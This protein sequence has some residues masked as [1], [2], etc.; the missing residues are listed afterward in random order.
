[1]AAS[2]DSFCSQTRLV[3]D[4]PLGGFSPLNPLCSWCGRGGVWD[5]FSL[6]LGERFIPFTFVSFRT[7]RIYPVIS[8]FTRTPQNGARHEPDVICCSLQLQPSGL[9]G[10][11]VCDLQ[12]LPL[13]R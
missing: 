13:V 1:M 10:Q 9:V 7:N 5:L 2:T 6:S 12:P 11:R 3:A 4:N 8:F